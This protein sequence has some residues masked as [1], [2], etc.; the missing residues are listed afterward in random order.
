MQKYVQ[1]WTSRIP[2][3]HQIF[4]QLFFRN[5]SLYMP[6]SAC[7]YNKHMQFNCFKS[8]NYFHGENFTRSHLVKKHI[9]QADHSDHPNHLSHPNHR[10]SFDNVCLRKSTGSIEFEN[11][12]CSCIWLSYQ[13]GTTGWLQL[14]CKEI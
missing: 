5:I 13:V 6:H 4:R 8:L 3:I 7:L 2:N 10:C 14:S 12:T 1:L 11:Q 9:A